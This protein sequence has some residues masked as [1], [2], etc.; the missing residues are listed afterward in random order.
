VKEVPSENEIVLKV[1][2]DPQKNETEFRAE[3]DT[4]SLPFPVTLRYLPVV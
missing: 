4:F 3:N 1:S 2:R